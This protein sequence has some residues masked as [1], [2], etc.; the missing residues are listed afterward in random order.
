MYE[1]GGQ[2]DSQSADGSNISAPQQTPAPFRPPGM[3]GIQPGGLTGRGPHFRP[4]VR[5][6]MIVRPPVTQ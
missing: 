6:G 1:G 3:Q 5:P 2:E 4:P